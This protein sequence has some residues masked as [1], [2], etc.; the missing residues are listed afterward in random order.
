MRHDSPVSNG[1]DPRFSTRNATRTSPAPAGPA[2]MSR[3]RRSGIQPRRPALAHRPGFASHGVDSVTA[4][5][6][7]QD[8]RFQ[9]VPDPAQLGVRFVA[10]RPSVEQLDVEAGVAKEVRNLSRGV[11]PVMARIDV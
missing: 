2:A 5:F 9:K 8:V 4:M 11:F 1:R 6:S 10:E 3:Y 7:R